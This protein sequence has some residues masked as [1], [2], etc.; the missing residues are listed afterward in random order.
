MYN[1]KL[2]HVNSSLNVSG[3]ALWQHTIFTQVTDRTLGSIKCNRSAVFL[4]IHLC[5][6]NKNA[7]QLDFHPFSPMCLCE[8]QKQEQWKEA[9]IYTASPRYWLRDVNYHNLDTYQNWRCLIENQ[10][11]R[12]VWFETYLRWFH[13]I[14]NPK[15]IFK[16]CRIKAYFH[17]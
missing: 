2:P 3:I 14:P 9:D 15:L 5:E 6:L 7:L 17:A 16:N 12:H 4:K 1:W 10:I 13:E 11:S 8:Q